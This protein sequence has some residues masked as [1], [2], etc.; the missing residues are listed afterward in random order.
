MIAIINN[1][2]EHL[3]PITEFVHD[4]L[5]NDIY[6]KN[7]NISDWNEEIINFLRSLVNTPITAITVKSN[8]EIIHDYQNLNGTVIGV[9]N[10]SILHESE[11]LITSAYMG[12]KLDS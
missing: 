1:N 12:I 3:I 9:S 11:R 10:E 5:T 4:W 6:I 7:H 8:N 2:L